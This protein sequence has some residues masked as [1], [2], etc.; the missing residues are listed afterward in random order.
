MKTLMYMA[1]LVLFF[2]NV[3]Y[4]QSLRV[5][6]AEYLQNSS[7]YTV[8]DVREKA[9]YDKGH[10]KGAINFP[11]LKTYE[12][13]KENGK[14]T[15]PIRMQKQLRAVG[16]DIDSNI[17]IYDKGGFLNSS[18]MF[19]TLEVYGFKNVKLLN[20]DFDLWY[21]K[22]KNKK[23]LSAKVPN[24]IPSEYIVTIDNKKLATKF[25]TLIAIKNPNQLIIDARNEPFYQGL[26]SKAKR[27]GHIP[28]ALNIPATKNIKK[29]H[30]GFKLKTLSEFKELYKNIDK[31]SKVITYCTHGKRSAANY[32]ALRELGYNVSAY[33]SSWQEWGNDFNLPVEN[34]SKK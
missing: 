10:I 7:N 20:I 18:R 1:S 19:W 3:L 25:T 15:N 31:N 29:D 32:F 22:D 4:A 17:L 11:V 8:I 30:T 12:H 2:Q 16:L 28:S 27:Y 34:P 21:K 9:D 6:L 23:Y 14:V 26:K 13:K 24:I 5:E 33:D